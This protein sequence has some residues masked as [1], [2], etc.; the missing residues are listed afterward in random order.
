MSMTSDWKSF[1]EAV[2]ETPPEAATLKEATDFLL[3]AKLTDPQSAAGITIERLEKSPAYPTTLPTQAFLA[4]AMDAL[5]AV[6]AARRASL[7]ANVMAAGSAAAPSASSA[8]A[9]AGMIAPLKAADTSSI[10][11]TAGLADL[12]FSMRIEQSLVDKMAAETEQAKR[13]GRSPFLY[14]E[15]ASRDVL[16][17][18]IT[19]ESVGGRPEEEQ[20]QLED[21]SVTSLARLGQ[22]LHKATEGK[23]CFTSVTQWTAAF[24]KYVPFAVALGHFSWAQAMMHVQT[25]LKLAEEEKAEGRGPAMAFIYEDMLRKQLER[26]CLA[27]DPTLKV[28][29]L[30]SEPDRATLS[31][32]RQRVMSAMKTIPAKAQSQGDGSLARAFASNQKEEAKQAAAALKR[33]NQ[34]RRQAGDAASQFVGRSLPWEASHPN[35]GGGSSSWQKGSARQ[36]KRNR[37]YANMTSGWKGARDE[38]R[39]RR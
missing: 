39:S 30:L 10:L 24:F 29:D 14:V 5:A 25:V 26:R 4:R 32:A 37:W 34:Q 31:A 18:W 23:R 16:P 20:D 11:T 38:K 19:P 13:Q 1:L 9:L 8:L 21:Q 3:A 27:N 15:L 33:Q 6:T 12:P 7:G 28:M 36:D 35:N 2:D 22:A 17:L